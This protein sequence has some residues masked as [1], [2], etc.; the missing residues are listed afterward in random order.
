[1]QSQLVYPGEHEVSGVFLLDRDDL[2]ELDTLLQEAKKEFDAY[3]RRRL[4]HRVNEH[5]KY[6]TDRHE[7]ENV[8]AEKKRIREETKER[9]P[10]SVRCQRVTVLCQSEN[11]IE[12][13]SF[14][15]IIEDER[16]DNESPIQATVDIQN[17]DTILRLRIFSSHP[18]DKIEISVAPNKEFAIRT[19]RRLRDWAEV[20]RQVPWWP[21]LDIAALMAGLWVVFMC[22][23]LSTMATGQKTQPTFKHRKL[24]RFRCL[25]R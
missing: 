22:F 8:D 24:L 12:A 17:A 7:I 2:R 13:A 11:K 23:G 1:M 10:F 25:A 20:R 4:T 16:L 21:K 14:A 9:H 5:L 19:A 3:V 15:S 6:I 18:R